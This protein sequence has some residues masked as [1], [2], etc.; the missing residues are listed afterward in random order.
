[1]DSIK[2]KLDQQLTCAICLETYRS[3]KGL[4]CMH[5]FCKKCI[6]HLVDNGKR[7]LQCPECR[8]IHSLPSSGVEGFPNNY[9]LVGIL[10]VMS[11]MSGNK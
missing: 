10:D 4:P 6:H 8:T 9:G 2:Q 11:Q 1:M 3:P 7:E 5:S